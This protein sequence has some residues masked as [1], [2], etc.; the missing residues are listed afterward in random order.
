MIY[1]EILKNIHLTAVNKITFLI[2]KLYILF[3]LEEAR[4]SKIRK[5]YTKCKGSE[6][7]IECFLSI[8]ANFLSNLL[9]E[10][11]KHII[12]VTDQYFLSLLLV[13]I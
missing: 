3:I 1:M 11:L 4:D 6:K 7:I 5:K 13:S 12:T 8:Q 9:L 2:S 10:E